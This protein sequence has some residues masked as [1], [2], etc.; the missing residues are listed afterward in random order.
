MV[1]SVRRCRLEI[2]P[3]T[4]PDLVKACDRRAVAGNPLAVAA[5]PSSGFSRQAAALGISVGIEAPADIEGHT[6]DETRSEARRPV[7]GRAGRIGPVL[8]DDETD[9]TNEQP[10]QAPAGVPR[11][12]KAR[13]RG[14]RFV[15]QV[16][17]A[18][19]ARE[20]GNNIL[21]LLPTGPVQGGFGERA[22]DALD[23][24]EAR[25]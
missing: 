7:L 25:P 2:A 5:I 16:A 15:R 20:R 18:T 10:R 6:T 24:A 12:M 9:D 11:R 22:S 14:V 1:S 21:G 4:L 19:S 8:L 3:A 23:L 17:Q 13:P